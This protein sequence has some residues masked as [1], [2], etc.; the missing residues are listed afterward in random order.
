[1]GPRYSIIF[2][3]LP[4]G[5]N[6]DFIKEVQVKSSGGYEAEYGQSTGGVMNLRAA[7]AQGT[8]IASGTIIV[9]Q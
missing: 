6:F 1:M 8:R 5:V 9:P 7:R 2:W 3:S 4:N